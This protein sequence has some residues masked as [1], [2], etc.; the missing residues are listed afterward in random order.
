MASS[1]PT[2]SLIYKKALSFLSRR[3]HS[4][5]ELKRKLYER[6]PNDKDLIGK[7]LQQLQEQNYLRDQAFS[8]MLL[9]HRAS[10]GYGPNYLRQELKTH[11]LKLDSA[12]LTSTAVQEAFFEGFK[13]QFR[14]RYKQLPQTPLERAQLMKYFRS[15]GYT[16]A[17]VEEYLQRLQEM[18]P[19]S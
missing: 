2:G 18:L 19:P 13:H 1:L 17:M 16:E 11:Q 3:E 6:F 4:T 14:R 12:L 10:Q 5:F 8:E 15:R 9:W 7:V